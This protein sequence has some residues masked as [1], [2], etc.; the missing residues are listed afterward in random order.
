MHLRGKFGSKFVITMISENT[1]K[2]DAFWKPLR[3]RR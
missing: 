1:L 3:M 2:K